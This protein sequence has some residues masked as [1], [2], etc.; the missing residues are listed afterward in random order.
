MISYGSEACFYDR[1]SQCDRAAADFMLPTHE[2][3]KNHS[4]LEGREGDVK[5]CTVILSKTTIHRHTWDKV[6]MNTVHG[7]KATMA[8]TLFLHSHFTQG[9]RILTWQQ[10]YRHHH[11]DVEI[12]PAKNDITA[13]SAVNKPQRCSVCVCV[14]V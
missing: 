6:Q 11:H 7:Q 3:C 9:G 10:A 8:D 4:H 14:C 5:H 2:V 13:H 1:A 12:L